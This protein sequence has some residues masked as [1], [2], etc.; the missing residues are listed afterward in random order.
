MKRIVLILA[1]LACGLSLTLGMGV[2][3]QTLV[4]GIPSEPSTLLPTSG[5]YWTWHVL[6]QTSEGLVTTALDDGRI[7]PALAE[8]WKISEDGRN[9]TFH[10]GQGIKFHDG[11]P[12]HAEAM[13]KSLEWNMAQGGREWL[14]S[15][16]EGID[17]LDEYTL[18]ITI[19]QPDATFLARLTTPVAYAYSPHTLNEGEAGFT[20]GYYSGTG[21]YKLVDWV[22]GDYIQYEAFQDYWGEERAKVSAVIERFIPELATR[23]PS[24]E[25]GEID[26]LYGGLSLDTI[27]M[28]SQDSAFQ[29]FYSS[30]SPRIRGLAFNV[31]RQPFDNPLVRAAI[32]YCVD[33]DRI[34]GG[35]FNNFAYSLYSVVPLIFGASSNVLPQLDSGQALQQAVDVFLWAGYDRDNPLH[36]TLSYPTTSEEY[37]RVATILRE[38]LMETGMIDLKLEELPYYD[39]LEKKRNGKLDLWFFSYW[40]YIPDPS[41][42]LSPFIGDDKVSAQFHEIEKSITDNT[43]RAIALA[44]WQEYIATPW[45]WSNYD[46]SLKGKMKILLKTSPDD[47]LAIFDSMPGA[48][49]LIERYEKMDHY[50]STIF[51][52]ST[53]PIW[54]DITSVTAFTQRN[55]FDV[56]WDVTG[57]IR[58]WLVRKE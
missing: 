37:Y 7:I 33:R 26:V 2:R 35:A 57:D 45:P 11:E 10:L 41:S 25:A 20:V 12:F 40:P 49:T 46:R 18:Q 58:L 1:F 17:V 47:I 31:S 24:L 6:R 36:I 56:C 3:G 27:Y 44:A 51:P 53:I 34:V 19:A 52:L 39:Y 28:L 22:P 13:K 8:A 54:Q 14:F 50:K 21:P 43:L 32:S 23:I 4:T 16:I 5:N 9:Y 29:S 42:Y 15:D 48:M 38:I 30:G 55:I